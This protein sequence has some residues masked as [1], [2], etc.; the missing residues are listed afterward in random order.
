MLPHEHRTLRA[1]LDRVNASGGDL[2]GSLDA[3]DEAV[4]AFDANRRMLHAN[5]RAT[6]LFGHGAGDLDGQSTDMLIP[7]RLRQPDAPPMT[8]TPDVMQVELPGLMRDGGERLIE[9][10]FA[11]TRIGGQVVFVM[12]V[13]DRLE[14][15]RAVERLRESEQRFQLFVSGVRDYAVYMLDANG[16]VSSWNAGAARV[17]GWDEQDIVGQSYEVFFTPDDRAAGLPARLLD[18]AAREGSHKTTGWRVRKDGTR[19]WVEGSLTVLRGEDGQIRGFAKITRDLTE[20]VRAEENE[21]RLI[22]ER[23][24]RAAA[25]EAERRIRASEEQITRLQR[26]TAALSEAATP[27]DVAAAVLRECTDAVA[28]AG[29]AVFVTASDGR[30]LDLVG[31]RGHPEETSATLPVPAAG[32]AHTDQRR[33]APAHAH[34][35]RELRGVR[36]GVSG[37][38]RGDGRG[39]L[40]GVGGV[41]PDRARR[42]AGRAGCALPRT[43]HVRGRRSRVP[44]DHERSVRA[45]AGSGAAIRGRVRGPRHG[46]IRQSRQGR[47]PGDARA[48]AAQPPGA[49]RDRGRIDEAARV[50]RARCG[51]REIIERQVVHLNRLVDDLLD[52]SRVARGLISLSR[53][54]IA[55]AD[56]LSKAVEQARPLLEQRN[57]QL[58]VLGPAGGLFVDADVVRMAQVVSN[59]L[60]NAAKYTPPGGHVWLSRRARGWPGRHPRP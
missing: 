45:G 35:P 29:G 13:K 22:A 59:L 1:I 16:R 32:G 6:Q 53:S 24:A 27:D 41:A 8:E 42:S 39:R 40:P 58:T 54:P 23:A 2:R 46:G 10:C 55:L 12:T 51:E 3:A 50:R 25:E 48:R 60:T 36:R 44:A 9:W 26:V 56:V 33:R 47:V 43:A 34:I 38:A 17:K 7:A 57:Q 18:E 20:R 37:A 5:P 49:D 4:I 19:F 52:V 15:E 28:A 14:L 11:S 31:Q 30:S 21:R